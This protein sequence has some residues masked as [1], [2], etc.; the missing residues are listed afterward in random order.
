MS[1]FRVED[2]GRVNRARPV[3]FTFD[4]ET[5]DGCEGDTVASALLANGVHLMGRGFKYHRP[6]GVLTA[7]SEEPNA[8]IGTSRGPGRFEPNTRATVQEIHGGLNAESQNRWPS[9]KFDIGAINDRLYMLF[10]AGFYYK[11][12]MW[13]KSFWDRVYEPF[14]RR[15]A[16]LGRAPTEIDPDTLRQPPPPLRRPDRRRRPRRSR[17]RA[18]RRPDR[19]GNRAG[20]REPRSRRHAALRA[21]REHRRRPRLGLARRDPRGTRRTAERPDP[22]PHHRHRLLPPEHGRPLPEADRPPDQPAAR[23]PPRTPLARPR[24]PGDPRPGRD[25]TSARLRR[26]RPPRRHAR[27]RRADLS[28][29]LR[30]EGREPPRDPHQPRQRVPRRLRP[31]RCRRERRRDHRHPRPRSTTPSSKGPGRA[32]SS[33]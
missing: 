32:A 10:S 23:R 17:R 14:I 8:L 7:G 31:R 4:G 3:T 1:K 5:Y 28:E 16:G 18:H 26:Q 29:P 22:D 9:L 11:T 20:R 25:R 27:R 6:R 19:R 30:R 13:P 33:C 12:F 24:R 15:A 2:G 21:L